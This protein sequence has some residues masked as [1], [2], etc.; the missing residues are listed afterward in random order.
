MTVALLEAKQAVV[1]ATAGWATYQATQAAAEAAAEQA[2]LEALAAK[3]EAEAQAAAQAQADA[4][5]AQQAAAEAKAAAE[6]AA[7]QAAAAEAQHR[8]DDPL[9]DLR[10]RL[11]EFFAPIARAFTD[12]GQVPEFAEGGTFAGGYRVVGEN[13][14]EL[15]FTGPSQITSNSQS[16]ALLDNSEVVKELKSLREDIKAYGYA[17]AK[18]TGKSAKVSDRWDIDGLPAERTI[19]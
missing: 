6:A 13:G 4:L 17:I 18:N 3:H 5:A 7:Q 8:A 12:Y 10:V 16:K 19:T 14:P 9:Y 15:E 11:R 1:D 2:R